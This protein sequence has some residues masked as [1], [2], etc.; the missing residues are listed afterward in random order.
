MRHGATLPHLPEVE[1][2]ERRALPDDVQSVVRLLG[3]RVVEQ[4]KHLELREL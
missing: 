2:L 3:H 1:V 4:A